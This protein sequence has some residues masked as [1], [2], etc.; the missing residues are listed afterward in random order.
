MGSAHGASQAEGERSGVSA[1]YDAHRIMLTQA[2]RHKW[3]APKRG[4]PLPGVENH[5]D[6]WLHD[7]GPKIGRSCAGLT[8]WVMTECKPQD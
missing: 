3:V 5:N 8:L 6:F 1:P 7:G 2:C 4:E